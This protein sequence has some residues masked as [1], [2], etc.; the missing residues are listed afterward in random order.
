MGWETLLE[1]LI[2]ID[3]FFFFFF[4]CEAL[5]HGNLTPEK[6]S[7]LLDIVNNRL[8]KGAHSVP[9]ISLLR[10]RQLALKAQ[11]AQ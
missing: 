2:F 8:G 3:G 6:A 1:N 5:F 10:S 7:Y 11:S 4:K 9:P